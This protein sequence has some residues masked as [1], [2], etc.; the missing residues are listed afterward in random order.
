LFVLIYSSLLGIL[1][2]M[3]GILLMS[4]YSSYSISAG[5][6]VVINYSLVNYQMHSLLYNSIILYTALIQLLH[7]KV[8]GLIGA[9]LPYIILTAGFIPLFYLIN[10]ACI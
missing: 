3:N 2:S 1:F 4:S 8:L 5:N 9:I 6:S 7:Y 10:A